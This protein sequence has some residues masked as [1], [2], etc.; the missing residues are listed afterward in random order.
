MRD[1][2]ELK[3]LFLSFVGEAHKNDFLFYKFILSTHVSQQKQT[4]NAKCRLYLVQSLCHYNF[5][6]ALRRRQ[7]DEEKKKSWQKR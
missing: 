5:P 2:S 7:V 6:M 3:T 4:K 1:T